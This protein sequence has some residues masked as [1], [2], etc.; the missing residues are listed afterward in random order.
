MCA[1]AFPVVPVGSIPIEARGNIQVRVSFFTLSHYGSTNCW[2][3]VSQL[4]ITWESGKD[5]WALCGSRDGRDGLHR[6]E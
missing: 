1:F 3:D 4:F 2:Y 5:K 6:E